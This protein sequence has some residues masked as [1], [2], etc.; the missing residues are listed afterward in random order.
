MYPEVGHVEMDPDA[1]WSGFITVVKGAV[2][3]TVAQ[4]PVATTIPKEFY[5]SL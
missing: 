5:M 4:C 3:G 2:Q 1:L